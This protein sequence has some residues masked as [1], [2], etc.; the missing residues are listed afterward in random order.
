MYGV[1]SFL[2][3]IICTGVAF[4][5]WYLVAQPLVSGTFLGALLPVWIAGL[6]GGFISSLFNPRQGVMLAFTCG[7]LLMIGF[8]WFR[9]GMSGMGLGVNPM[10]TLWPVWF[11]PAFYIGAYSHIL[12]LTRR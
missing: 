4:V 6:V 2:R 3:T 9:H 11:P 7:I 5:V 8:L 12:F 1:L 10:L